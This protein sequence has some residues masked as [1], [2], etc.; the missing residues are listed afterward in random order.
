MS[1]D[2][3]A[4]VRQ[5][6]ALSILIRNPLAGVIIAPVA[7]FVVSALISSCFLTAYNMS[8]IAGLPSSAS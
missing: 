7:I 5:P 1:T 6:S 3:S 4:A 2:A 8:V